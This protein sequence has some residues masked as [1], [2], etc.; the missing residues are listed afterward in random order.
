MTMK[1]MNIH[2]LFIVWDLCQVQRSSISVVMNNISDFLQ[3]SVNMSAAKSTFPSAVLLETKYLIR[4]RGSVLYLGMAMEI[5][6]L[7]Y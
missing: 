7:P 5:S 4:E 2:Y 1:V 6:I 3:M